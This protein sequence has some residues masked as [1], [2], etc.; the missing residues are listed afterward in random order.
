MTD[1]PN[2]P[3]PSGATSADDPPG[4]ID[5]AALVAD[6]NRS[7]GTGAVSGSGSA[8]ARDRSGSGRAPTDGRTGSAPDPGSR[9]A[10]FSRWLR[11]GHT[12]WWRIGYPV[13]IGAVVLLL[14][15]GLVYS[16]LRVILDSTDGQLVKRVTDPNAPGY[17]AVVTKTPTAIV[18]I[19]GA[20]GALDGIAV[21]ALTSDSSGGVLTMPPTLAFSTSFGDLPATVAWEAESIDGLANAVGSVLNLSFADKV[22]VKSSEWSQLLS[23]AGPLTVA[24]PDPVRDAKDTVVFQK[25]TTQVKPEQIAALLESKGPKENESGRTL[26]QELFW[27]AW[28]AQMKSTGA[29]FPGLATSGLGRYITTLAHGQVSVSSLPVTPMPAMNGVPQRYAAVPEPTRAS[30]AAIVPFPDGAAGMRPRV[31]VL[32]GTGRLGNGLNAAIQLNAGGGQVDVVGNA[33]SFGQQVTQ[34]TWYDGSSEAVALKMKAAL[35]G[36]GEIVSNAASNAASDIMIVLGEDYL[37]KYGPS[38]NPSTT[39]AA[40]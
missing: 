33:R 11:D 27:K 18:A 2:L 6:H 34:I 7:R 3:R 13:V 38:S 12:R 1:D 40:G 21:L 36:I 29:Q 26:R 15:P 8:V 22:V 10:R 17:E 19:V 37:A 16:G 35:G 20:E 39:G 32:D 28:I 4:G 14:L 23:T 30:V 9:R 5:F 25:G 24:L 31:R